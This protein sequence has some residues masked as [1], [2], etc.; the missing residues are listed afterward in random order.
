VTSYLILFGNEFQVS[1]DPGHLL[2]LVYI[3][4]NVA[5]TFAPKKWFSSQK[6]F[7]SLVIVDTAI[8]SLGMVLSEKVATDF[9]L[10]FFLI[11]IFASVSRDFKLLMT[12]SGISCLIYGFLLY[13]WGLLGSVQ[14]IHYLLRIP[15][16]FIVSAF[17]G[18]IV[19]SFAEEKQKALA[20]LEDRYGNL[21][22][23][24]ND[25]IMILRNPPLLIANVNR[26]VE[27]LTEFTKGEL[28]GRNVLS[29]FR[30]ADKEKASSF[31][32]KVIQEGEGR[33]D[34][35]CLM[36]KKGNPLEA[37]LSIK[38]INFENESFLQV[39]FRD[40]TEQRRLEKKIQE[41]K[42]NLEA[43]F[44]GIRDQ[45]SVQ[46]PEYR[47]LRVNRAVSRKYHSDFRELIGKKCYETYYQR[48]QP[49][50][51]C[52][53]AV[54][55]KTKAFATSV[56]K[57]SGE[58]TTLRFF[59][60][61]IFDEKGNVFSVIEH[62]QDI[63][64]EQRLQEQLVQS[65]K[66]AGIGYLASGVAHEINNPLSGII[67]MAEAAQEEEDLPTI[68]SH[69]GDI[70]NCSH[71][72]SEIVKGLRSYCRVAKQEE[73]SRVDINELLDDS[74][75]MVRMGLKAGA[76][77][78]VKKFEPVE[79]VE[80]NRGELQQVFVNLITNAFQAVNGNG[81]TITL[82]IRSLK[83]IIEVKVM[84]T[85]VGIPQK[86]LGKI[87]DPFFTTKKTG[88]G[89]GLGLNVVYR[90]VSKYGGTIDVESKEGLGTTFTV[91]FPT[92]REEG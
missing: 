23:N 87:F 86:Y 78:V 18:T 62:V 77:E 3:L 48:S 79:K 74:V 45:L 5:L 17:Y 71:R 59:S 40:L 27:K 34:T 91:R 61:P 72:I 69:L 82:S 81:G 20:I 55:I 73:L 46:S 8:V 6:I 30:P 75:K 50:E 19:L 47:I 28:L 2:I 67:G 41:A 10:V 56:M 60:Y 7:Y 89:T 90:I 39:I 84:D 43:V 53:V 29:L 70:L 32:D 85:G 13:S 1:L 35:L 64:D 92:R 58:D 63:T 16:I 38:S 12:I 15:F 33:T 68:R 21:F 9:Y 37:D 80:A 22:E 24:A 44:D 25:G 4:S 83:D 52:P 51:R 54:S 31:L 49:C 76:V 42:R 88:E 14:G 65:E 57:I 11:M 26:E 36:R 66:L